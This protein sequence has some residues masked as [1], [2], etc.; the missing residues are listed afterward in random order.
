MTE[1]LELLEL[2][3]S[4]TRAAGQEFRTTKPASLRQVEASLLHGKEIKLAADRILDDILLKQLLPT[5]ISLLSEES[6]LVRQGVDKDLTWIIDPL[7][8]TVNYLR[9]IGPSAI[10]VALWRGGCPLFGVLYSLNADVLS[11]GGKGLGAWSHETPIQVSSIAHANQAVVATG[12][13]ARFQTDDDEKVSRFCKLITKFNKVRMIGSAASS[14]LLVAQGNA[15]AYVEDQIMIWDVAAGLAILQGA[16]GVFAI[17]QESQ[18]SPCRVLAS[19]EHL[20]S[21]L[22][23]G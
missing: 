7:D 12:V 3:K 11:W 20:L 9:G 13:P 2:A 1:I 21:T 19:N 23:D 5:G 4:A 22:V 6:G 14:L 8:G 10:S 17:D 15:D 18:T 16:G